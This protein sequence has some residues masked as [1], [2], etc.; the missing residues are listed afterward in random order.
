[1][2]KDVINLTELLMNQLLLLDGIIAEGDIKVQRKNQVQLNL[3]PAV[4]IFSKEI[5]GN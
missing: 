1:M 2:E 5:L 3:Y 4:L